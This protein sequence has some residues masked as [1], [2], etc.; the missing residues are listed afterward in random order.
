M[1][2]RLFLAVVLSTLARNGQVQSRV[3][4]EP[5][6]TPA[7]ANAVQL[8]DTVIGDARQGD[9]DY[10]VLDIAAGTRLDIKARARGSRAQLRLIDRDGQTQLANAYYDPIDAE[11]GPR[12][13]Y[14]INTAGRYYLHMLTNDF[15]GGVS[16]YSIAVKEFVAPAPGPGD[17]S[18]SFAAEM[19]PTGIVAAASGDVYFTAGWRE[20]GRIARVSASG[21]VTTLVASLDNSGSLAFGGS[22]DLLVPGCAVR[23]GTVNDCLPQQGVVW[24]VSPSGSVSRFAEGLDTPGGIE[25]GPDGDVWVAADAARLWHFNGAGIQVETIPIGSR[26]VDLAFSPAGELHYTDG[27][28]LFKLSNN[29]PVFLV[30]TIG[31][32]NLRYLAFDRDGF[33]YVS[34]SRSYA[35]LTGSANGSRVVLLD[36]QYRIVHDPLAVVD[37]HFGITGVGGLAFARDPTGAPTTRLLAIHSATDMMAWTTYDEI[38]ALNQAGIRAPGWIV[39]K[40]SGG[41]VTVSAADIANALMGGPSLTPEQIEF[42][43]THGN[44]NGILDVG[45]LRAYLR[46]QGQLTPH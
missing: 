44:H 12:I 23:A 14:V 7:T 29:R 31:F 28:S 24:R 15:S 37:D 11:P 4:A 26:A 16:S 34:L 42:L 30:E 35:S 41:S 46:T 27:H 3:E 17:P 36:P 18:T 13:R 20:G 43:D 45:D 8:G 9:H 10:F 21:V 40:Q 32:D 33:L 39:G 5:N 38:A 22:G 2:G 1:T 6:D 19:R 25:V